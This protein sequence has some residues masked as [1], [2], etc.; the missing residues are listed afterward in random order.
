M[1]K[2]TAVALVASGITILAL[3]KNKKLS[4]SLKQSNKDLTKVVAANDIMQR[5]IES[6]LFLNPEG[7]LIP[8]ALN[9]D[10]NAFTIM[11]E[12]NML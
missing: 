11:S 12:N 1:N 10:M 4:K 5:I 6:Q 3:A 7:F 8:E 2:L 9:N